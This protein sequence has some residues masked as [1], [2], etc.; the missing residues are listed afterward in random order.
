[1]MG[2]SPA[3]SIGISNYPGNGGNDG[4][5]GLFEMDKQI[6]ILG[7]SDGTSNTLAVGERATRV[8]T[9]TSPNGGQF[10]A[11]WAGISE[12][13]GETAGGQGGCRGYTYYRMVDG[14]TNTG[15]K[16]P[17]VA[18]SSMHPGGANFLLCDGSVRFISYNIPWTD[19]NTPH[20][21]AQMGTFNKLG[22]RDD[23]QPVS[24]Y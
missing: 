3:V 15:T 9:G 24:D 23:G 11:L 12:V 22:Q 16:L 14:E 8:I 21:S 17:D 1:M 13:G 5:T 2:V 10:A 19:P 4:N 18:F 7:I 20:P 6:N